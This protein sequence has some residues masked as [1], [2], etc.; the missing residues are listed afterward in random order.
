MGLVSLFVGIL[1]VINSVAILNEERFLRRIGL[2]H[3]PQDISQNSIR[4]K[5]VNLL[6]AVR[7]LMRVPLIFLNLIAILLGLVLL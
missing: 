5:I 7:T 6:N 2:G 4:A 1:L 3:T